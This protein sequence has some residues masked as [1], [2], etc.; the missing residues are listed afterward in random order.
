MKIWLVKTEVE[1]AYAL[2]FGANCLNPGNLLAERHLTEIFL[3]P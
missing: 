1:L 3:S 2:V